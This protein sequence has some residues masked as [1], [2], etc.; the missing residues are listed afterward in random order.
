M[1]KLSVCSGS[2]LIN[3]G[4]FQIKEDASW[5]VFSSSSLTEESVEGIITTTDSFVRWHL[6]VWLNSVFKTEQLPAS[7]TNLNTSLTNVNG[8]NLSHVCLL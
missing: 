1:E 5:D 3:D 6:S 7:I 4:W 2:D 8:N